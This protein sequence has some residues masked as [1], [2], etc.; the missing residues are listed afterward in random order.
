MITKDKWVSI[1]RAAGFSE[2][3]MERWHT[4][5]E[6]NAPQEH[7]EF[8]EFLHIGTDE[9]AKIR[10]WSRKGHRLDAGIMLTSA[11]GHMRNPACRGRRD[12]VL[13]GLLAGPL[14]QRCLR[15]R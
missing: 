5:F 4:E 8:L 6:K 11:G 3:D 15:R 2:H 10:E 12:V 9:I 13:G 14:I 7:Q 1:M